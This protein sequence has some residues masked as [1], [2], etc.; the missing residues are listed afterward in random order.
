[1]SSTWH[2]ED[3]VAG[4]RE[5]ELSVAGGMVSLA[6]IRAT[7]RRLWYL[8]VGSMVLGV[9]LAACWLALVTPPSVGTVTLLL[10]HD[11]ST[12]PD[13]AMATDI[14]LLKTRTVAQQ[15]VDELGLDVTPDELLKT[16][17]AEPTTSSVLRVDIRGSGQGDAVRRARL[18]AETYLT[19]REQ[20]L[21]QQAKAVTE[22]YRTRI[23]SLQL[24]VDD[25]TSQYD[26]ITAGNGSEAEASDVLASRG[27]LIS[28]ITGLENQIENETLEANA[29]VAASR[30]LDQAA[31]VPQSPLRRTAMVMGSGLI[32]GLGLGLGL[33]MV[34]AITTGRLRSRADVSMAMGLPVTFSAGGVVPRRHQDRPHHEA[35]LD[36]LVDGLETAVPSTDKRPRRLSLVTIDC[37]REGAKVIAGLARRLGAEGSV[38]AVDSADTGLLAR[39]LGSQAW[40]A[41][42]ETSGSV[43]VVSGPTVDTVADVLLCLVPFDFGRGLTHLES[44]ASRCVVLVKAG[45]STTEQLSTVARSAR[46]AGLHVEFVML[47]G[48]DQSDASFGGEGAVEKVKAERWQ[49]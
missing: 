10:A 37:E 34:Y 20:Q 45:R 31:F 38:L 39:E 44:T 26:A 14:S 21:T 5:T 1:M 43:A 46:T 41:S 6:F 9:S 4:G 18:L 29:V 23:D 11:P 3:E 32:G 25:L 13:A 30:V 2:I 36:V 7:L 22:A 33:V 12:D 19:Y 35:S 15:L 40:P 24:Q 48:A 17:I 28:E 42:S 27:Q 49:S 8:W 47:V 16:I